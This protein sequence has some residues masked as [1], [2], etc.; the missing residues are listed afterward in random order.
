[1]LD[2][3]HG[4]TKN[5]VVADALRALLVQ[6]DLTGSLYIGYP[7]FATADEPITVDA[8][9]VT[10]EHGLVAFSF[11]DHAGGQ[12]AD[13]DSWNAL[14]TRQD[15]LFFAV[16]TNLRR[17]ESL[18]RGRAPA[19]DVRTI[20]L[21]QTTDAI[22]AEHQDSFTVLDRLASVITALPPLDKRY[23]APL[24]AAL[25]RV[26]TIRPPKKRGNA[27]SPGSRGN[28]LKHIESQIANLDLW[29]KK[30]AIESPDGPQRIRGLAGSG[31]TVV[32][33]QKA[34]YLH[35][36]HPD[37]IIA[38]TFSSR[39]LYQQFKDLV[40][41]FSYE[42]INDEP[43]W[44]HLRILHAW[45]GRTREGLYH[46][47]SMHC[48]LTPHNFLYGQ[49]RYGRDNAFG[50]VC[51]ELLSAINARPREPLF[52]AV[53]IDEAQDLP[54][55]FFRIVHHMTRSPKRIVWAYD[56]LQKLS[57]SALPTVKEQFGVDAEDRP[58]VSLSNPE[59]APHQDIVLPMCYRNTPWALALA[60]GLGLGTARKEGL[61]QSFDDPSLWLDIGYH[62]VA[63]DLKKGEMVTLERRPTSYPSYFPDLL[64]NDDPITSRVFSDPE[65][66]ARWI[67]NSIKSNL[68]QDELE[69]D[70][71]LI[72]LPDAYR[73]K[74]EATMIIRALADAQ[75]GAHL[76]GVT[77]SQDE[78]FVPES[79]A[80][81]N[82]YRSK[83]NEAPMV[84]VANAQHCVSG[85]RLATDRN[86]LFTA[87]TRSRGWVRL[88]GWGPAMTELESEIDTIRRDNYRLSFSVPTDDELETIR[89]LHREL[90]ARERGRIR[91]VEEGLTSVIKALEQGE[92]SVDDLP[93]RLRTAVA[94]HFQ[95]E[96]RE[97]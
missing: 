62:A 18:R 60:H 19:I 48:G 7:V 77:T 61:V 25:Q 71:I 63:G 88:S 85:R 29:Q 97:S 33:A 42:H 28:A 73:A 27:T 32:L 46:Q 35:A 94:R 13:V 86:I 59:N 90:S 82:I 16:D 34:A 43:D 69:H 66:Q 78:L 22:P 21:V 53:L 38:L 9:L 45:G 52:D 6:M 84:Y 3:T 30:A 81:A 57:D 15:Q 23:I 95:G 92:V 93:S 39:A 2:V 58:I 40:R 64:A 74:S 14:A 24:Q 76:A 75:I 11:D 79:I 17:H 37:W 70:D 20:T 83:G 55:P 87:I 8:L 26:S 89:S 68:E 54:I 31:K 72:V 47:V 51:E 1:M 10:S 96:T 49:S 12:H 65:S 36:E 44:E 91:E 4:E 5:Q 41:R 67:A 50:G 56:E 80:I